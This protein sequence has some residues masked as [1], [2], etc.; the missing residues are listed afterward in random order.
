MIIGINYNTDG[1]RYIAMV[2]YLA[3]Q[4]DEKTIQKANN[5]KGLFDEVYVIPFY[6]CYRELITEIVINGCRI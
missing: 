6:N 4:T 2:D 5:L 1:T 3:H